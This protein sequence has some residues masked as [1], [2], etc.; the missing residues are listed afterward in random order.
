M[1][2]RSP[3]LRRLV[4]VPAVTILAV[5]LLLSAPLWLLASLFV[6]GYRAVR[7]QP[8]AL[9]RLWL[10]ALVY[11]WTSVGGLIWLGASWIAT[12]G[13]RDRVRLVESAYRAQSW[14]AGTLYRGLVWAFNLRIEVEG[15][16]IIK[17]GPLVVLI[18]HVSILDTLLPLNLI[19]RRHDIRLR[20][21]LKQE[22]RADPALDICGSRLPNYFVDREASN[23]AAEIDGIVALADDLDKH[24]GV[25]IYPEGRLATAASR[26]KAA[27]RALTQHPDLAHLTGSYRHVIAPRPAGTLAL[28]NATDCDVL[29]VG[30]YGLDKMVGVRSLF[31]KNLPGSTITVHFT[32]IPRSAIPAPATARWLYERWAALD[33]WVDSVATSPDGTGPGSTQLP[34][35]GGKVANHLAAPPP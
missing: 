11:A 32:R 12:F 21:V 28:V 8:G 23:T 30:H 5:L 20:Y 7:R 16:G 29:I 17:P 1:L 9:W 14:W 4:S 19:T 25:I 33:D 27:Q 22:L 13:G 10:C 6:D 35:T 24:S 3:L 34:P 31:D 2:L 15:D 26:A 18:R